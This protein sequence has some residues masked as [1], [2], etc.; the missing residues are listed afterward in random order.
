MNIILTGGVTGGHF[1]P[2]IAV[3]EE[4]RNIQ[5]ENKVLEMNLF[6]LSVNSYDTKLLKKN[7]I[8]F[9]KISAGKRRT[10]FSIKNFFD[11]FKTLLGIMQSFWYVFS[12]YPDVIFSKG[13]SASF[14]V[15]LAGW[16]FRIP[17]VVHESDTVP[18][19]VNL[20]TGK[21]ANSI[22]VAFEESSKYFPKDKTLV[23]GRPMLNE[24]QTPSLIGAK[25][26][27]QI[28]D[29]IPV[30]LFL[31]GSQGAEKINN[32]VIDSLGK[33]IEKYYII[34][35][36]GRNNYLAVKK[37]TEMMLEHNEFK[38]RYKV[39]DYLDPKGMSMSASLSDI[40]V[41]RS[42]S[43][44]FEIASWAKPSILIP[45]SIAHANHQYYNALAYEKTGACIVLEEQ[46]LKASVLSLQI[47]KIIN[48]QE[49]KD[50]MSEG[51][52]EFH[53]ES[54]GRKVAEKIFSIAD[55]HQK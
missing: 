47:E 30:I 53:K 29:D 42:G 27:L 4:L 2:V 52:K 19:R 1:Y 7:G 16:F 14:P 34:H 25:E 24:I 15:V 10:Y 49:L 23:V 9:Q 44:L 48:D 31:G 46:N 26:H 5:K 21:R 22:M 20:W 37:A 51:A 35:Q 17:I 32:L 50:K 3:A 41:S 54:A 43:A 55:E 11:P 6:F 39:F 36:T 18:G 13:G 8:K 45:L 38:S 33:L 40:I 12:I 28:I